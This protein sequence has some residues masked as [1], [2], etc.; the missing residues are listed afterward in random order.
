[1]PVY[2]LMFPF[3][4][5]TAYFALMNIPGL[6]EDTAFLA[7]AQAHLPPWL[8]GLIAG[9]VALTA[10]LVVS[11]NALAIAGLFSKNIYRAARPK[12]SE[13]ELILCVRA[14][15]FLALA[16]GA[17]LAIKLPTLLANVIKMSYIGMAQLLVAFVFAFFWRKATPA[18]IAAGMAAGFIFLLCNWH[19]ATVLGLNKGCAALAVNFAAAFLASHIN[20]RRTRAPERYDE[21]A[22][23]D[24][25]TFEQ[26]PQEPSKA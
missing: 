13:G 17:L 23:S 3:L 22:A 20:V 21:Y 11:V 26:K 1:M 10:V 8:L 18:G 6:P 14:A 2:M 24:H 4:V 7:V 19:S 16:V 15:T 25:W 9:G 12:A 5:T